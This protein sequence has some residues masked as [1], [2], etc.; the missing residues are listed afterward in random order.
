MQ[1]LLFFF[2]FLNGTCSDEAWFSGDHKKIISYC[3]SNSSSRYWKIIPDIL[4]QISIIY[5]GWQ[6]RIYADTD[7]IAFL[8]KNINATDF[9]YYCNVDHLPPPLDIVRLN[10]ITM[11]R[12]AAIGD[13]R[14]DV[15]LFRDLDSEVIKFLFASYLYSF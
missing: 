14:I 9:L 3:F 15:A 2:S 10:P 4:E 1:F 12:F 6:V 11:W 8:K 13:P 5:P 7:N